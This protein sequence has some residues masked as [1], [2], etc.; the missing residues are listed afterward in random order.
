[1]SFALGIDRL[2]ADPELRRPLRGRRLA[3]L[4]HPA[5][6]TRD[7]APS[8]DA[9][10]GCGDLQLSCAFGPQ[11]GM[12][13]DKQDNMVESEDY[14]DPDIGIPV[15][16]LY[17][18]VRRPT[19]AM[20][21]AF[22]VLLVDLQD[23]GCRV[24][25]FLTTLCYLLEDCAAAGKGLWV[26]DRP[27]PAGRPVEG[28]T[29]V[30][31]QQSFV[32]VAPIPM[33]HGLTLGEAARWFA[34]HRKLDLDLRVVEMLDYRPDEAPGHGWP[35]GRL[36]WVHPSPNAAGLNMARCYA[37]TVLLE[38]T[39]LSE[40]RGTTFSLEV[41]G[42]PGLR[43]RAILE[44]MRRLAPGW[45]EGCRL[46]ACTFEPTFHKHAGQMCRGLQIH[47]VAPFHDPDRFRPYR[48]I[49]AFLA[50]LRAVHPE[51]PLW[52]EPPYEYETERLPIDVINGGPLLR[53]WVDSRPED[54]EALDAAL[55]ADEEAWREARAPFLRYP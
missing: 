43:V 20:L 40:G 51:I 37:G 46:R 21:D 54:G 13:G 49:A 55:A 47:A 15:F 29:L 45:L 14:R 32:G 12:R 53:E 33:R 26:L 7:L 30:P 6:V 1:M 44:R 19:A 31:G 11:H 5:S 41:A 23:L 50:A 4:G 39:T 36:P 22:D 35:E 9:L 8:L 3:L 38:G 48:L 16:S 42:A 2:V 10:A 17:G 34:A 28:S 52:K 27:N 24:Y 25:T 18:D